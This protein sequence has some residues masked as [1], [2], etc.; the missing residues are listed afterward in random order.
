MIEVKR[1]LLKNALSLVKKALPKIII[2][3][4]RGHILFQVQTDTLILSATNND[5][6][7]LTTIPLD[8][9]VNAI[10]SFTVEPKLLEKLLSKMDVEVVK[11]EFMPADL[12]VKVYTADNDKSF[13][14]LQ[15]FP[16]DRMLTFNE[17]LEAQK[18]EY[19]IDKKV[20]IFSLD[21]ASCFLAPPKEDLKQ[22]DFVIINKGFVYAGNG[23]NKMGFIVFKTFEKIN[24]MK[25]RKVVLPLMRSFIETLE[26][27]KVLLSETE[28]DISIRSMDGTAYYG[29]LKSSVDAPQMKTEYV[30]SEGP[31]TRIEKNKFIKILDR[32]AVS[33]TTST[34]TG[35]EVN[36][37]GTGEASF[38]DL[39]IVSNL[40]SI[41]RLPCV[42]INDTDEVHHHILDYKIFKTILSSF[43]SDKEVRLHINDSAR[44]FK[45]YNNGEINGNKYILAGIGSYSKVLKQ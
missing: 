31:Y 37:S 42:R 6:K 23:S 5:L 8:K 7:A 18:S 30:K 10:C 32:V 45:I 40:K 22:Y 33:A 41:E 17:H 20:L 4:E 1:E 34:G 11:I 28:K 9:P 3:Q 27:D 12:T 13:S 14:T 35:I 29:F 2:Q 21:Y 43:D 25:I 15:S 36:L 26:G 16:P 24:N 19:E 39:S 38:I 44:F